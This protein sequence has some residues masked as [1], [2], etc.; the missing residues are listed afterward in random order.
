VRAGH[1]LH[2]TTKLPDFRR[3]KHK[4][5]VIRHDA[6]GEQLHGTLSQTARQADQKHLVV[7]IPLEES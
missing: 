7:A 1:L 6:V 4:M 2:E 3:P 5:K